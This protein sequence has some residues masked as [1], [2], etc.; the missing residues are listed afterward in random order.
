MHAHVAVA[1]QSKDVQ[2]GMEVK[3]ALSYIPICTSL[4]FQRDRTLLA[5]AWLRR[6]RIRTS[7]VMHAHVAVAR[8]SKDVQI[9]MEVKLAL[10]YLFFLILSNSFIGLVGLRGPV[11]AP[12][13]LRHTLP[14]VA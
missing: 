1:R 9:G 8:Q 7:Q 11:Q 4:M 13:N 2:I 10:S 3:L 12:R 5:I 14:L 6:T